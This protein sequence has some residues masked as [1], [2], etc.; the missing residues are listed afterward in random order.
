MK[1]NPR[2]IWN[3]SRKAPNLSEA[4]LRQITHMIC[5]AADDIYYELDREADNLRNLIPDDDFNGLSN[6]FTNLEQRVTDLEDW[7]DN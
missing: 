5:A 3:K 4:D 1:H 7:R 2:S 6:D